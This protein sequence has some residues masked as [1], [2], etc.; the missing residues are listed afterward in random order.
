[1]IKAKNIIIGLIIIVFF[2]SSTSGQNIYNRV[3]RGNIDKIKPLLEKN[4]EI[5][6]LKNEFG[7]APLHYA[8]IWAE[9]NKKEIVVLLIDAGADINLKSSEGKI[10]LHYAAEEGNKE[11]TEL[12]I[13]KG[14]Q[15]NIRDDSGKFPLFYSVT[16]GYKEIID[17][18]L[19]KGAEVNT[20]ND[21]GR[22]MLHGAASCG[23]KGL[24]DLLIEKGAHINSK[25]NS[26]GTLLHSAAS[27][28]LVELVKFMISK[29][30][31]LNTRNTYSLTPLHLSALRGHKTVVDLL[32]SKGSDINIKSNDG[33]TPL[34]CALSSGY[35]DVT[36]LLIAGGAVESLKKLPLLKGKYL[37]QKNPGV[38]P[39]IFAPGIISTMD[40]YE[41]SCTF[42]PDASELLF[43]WRL[44]G[45][46]GNRIKHMK[47]ESSRWT[48][49]ELAPFAYDCFEFEPVF[50]PG[51]KKIFY[52]SRRPLPGQTKLNNN[53]DVWIIEK[54]IAGWGKP[55]PIGSPVSKALPMYVSVTN[56][57]TIYFTGNI[58]RGIYKSKFINGK[59]SVPERLPEEINYLTNA[60]HPYIAPDESYLIFDAQPGGVP[61]DLYISFR[62][63][64][65]SWTKAKNMGYRINS[66]SNELCAFVSM[67][68]KYLFFGRKG[69]IYWVDAKIIEE[70]KPESL[71]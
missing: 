30:A 59:Y 23:H 53:T 8:I 9:K 33:S 17:L 16:G 10:P 26:G 71:K 55:Y 50:S 21:L 28:G 51:G 6:N 7:Y 39:K 43:T 38:E 37:G 42:S 54:T 19:A 25:S 18:L 14:A 15:I 65:R 41:F 46:T 56:D 29:G 40:G 45:I 22:I 48:A 64:D 1:M 35:S 31:N 27:G 13:T 34:H 67:D 12:L 49:P 5:V 68:G 61:K 24:V 57:G 2:I 20:G 62:R 3:W 36:D 63:Q 44:P 11:I 60:G 69:D 70:L 4:P 58:K 52:G 32:I 47:C 66:D